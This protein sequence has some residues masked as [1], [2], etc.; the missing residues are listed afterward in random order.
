MAPTDT[1]T[2]RL[3]APRAA[4]AAGIAFAVL[5]AAAIVLMRLAIPSGDG[6]EPVPEA[7]RWAVR[8][9]LEIVPFAGIAFLWFMGA[10]R[11]HV[12]EVEDKF[13]STVFLGS[14]FICAATLFVAAG[15]AGTVLAEDSP[16]DFGR[17]YA[18]T[19][20]ATYSMRMAAVFVLSTSMMGRRLGVFS[21]PLIVVGVLAGLVLLVVGSSVPW[22]E[23]VFPAWA[24]VISVHI[25]RMRTR[26]R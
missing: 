26:P 21:R 23:L 2:A 12:G 4:G 3:Y 5:L 8:L 6:G 22:S 24:F 17:H 25:L 9:A 18:Y 20:L 7:D 13:F 16:S 19:V 10:M 15:A 1:A 14:G 11:A